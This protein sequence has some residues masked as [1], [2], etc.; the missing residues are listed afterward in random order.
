MT[1]RTLI[2]EILRS[3]PNLDEKLDVQVLTRDPDNVVCV[4]QKSIFRF[5]AGR[6]YVE[7]PKNLTQEK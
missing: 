3:M 4:H 6:F 1:G 2:M 5:S 7:D